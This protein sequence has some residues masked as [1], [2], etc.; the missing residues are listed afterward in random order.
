MG[1]PWST[2]V[3]V[4]TPAADTGAHFVGWTPSSFPSS[5]TG[6]LTFTATFAYNEYTVTFDTSGPGSLSGQKTF[7]NITHGTA[8]S[9]AV[10]VPTPVPDAD[11]FFVGWTPSP[12]PDTVTQT[13]N[14]TALF[15]PKVHITLVANS[16][17]AT[18]DG[19]EHSIT[20]YTELAGLTFTGISASG[21]GTNAGTFPVTFLTDSVHVM[22]NGEDVTDRFAISYVDGLLVI[23]KAQAGIAI[24]NKSKVY[25]QGDPALTAVVSGT[26][27][28]ETL[29]YTLGRGF[30]R[31]RGNIRDHG[32][33]RPEPEL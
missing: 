25:G 18:Y 24:D 17:S 31:E 8:W 1:P 19:S 15:A 2:A 9:T 33:A 27:G 6:D 22:Q 3:T 14:F 7:A 32:Y 4:P 5:V 26:I 20:G 12:F 13:R 29:H 10:T 21:K 11:S 16:G 28:E 23:N 30:G